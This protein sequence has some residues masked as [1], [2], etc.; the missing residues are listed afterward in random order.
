MNRLEKIAITAAF[1]LALALTFS[2]SSGGGG[3]SEQSYNYC[4]MEDDTCLAG[5]F[6]ASTC[7][8]QLSNSCPDGSTPIVGRSSSSGGGTFSRSSSGGQ[9]VPFNE[10]S[11][12]YISYH[13]DGDRWHIGDDAYKGSGFIEYTSFYGKDYDGHYH[14]RVGSVTNGIVKLELPQTIPDDYLSDFFYSVPY[15][16]ELGL[17]HYDDPGHS[18]TNIKSFD[19]HFVLTDRNGD[20]IGDLDIRNGY[21]NDGRIAWEEIEYVYFSK[22]G[23]IACSIEY[24]KDDYVSNYN[25]DAQKGWNRIYEGIYREGKDG[26]RTEHSTNNIL[27][28]EV[29][30][31]IWQ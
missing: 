16:D 9:G 13:D 10:N 22:A 5:P 26:T 6:T 14:I 4:V 31:V 28:K 19:G 29:K 24:N 20:Y 30:W 7:K 17:L 8:Y 25:I 21:Y 2:C 1:G 3:S 23:K 12:I 18:C 11:Q 15:Y 27:T